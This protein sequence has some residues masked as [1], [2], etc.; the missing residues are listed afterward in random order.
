MTHSLVR[1]LLFMIVAPMA[2]VAEAQTPPGEATLGSA[3]GSAFAECWYRSQAAGVLNSDSTR[4]QQACRETMLPEIERQQRTLLDA[5]QE[6]AAAYQ[7]V[8]A[9]PPDSYLPRTKV[10]AEQRAWI[11]YRQAHCWIEGVRL[12]HKQW[13]Q[14]KFAQCVEAEARSR[15]AYLRRLAQ[16]AGD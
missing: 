9:L 16:P 6:M 1:A 8:Q 3:D 12:L 10:L 2:L 4:F 5:E 15:T 11:K 14:Y 13:S 7:A